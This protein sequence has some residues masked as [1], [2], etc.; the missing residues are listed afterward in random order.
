MRLPIHVG[1]VNPYWK[2]GHWKTSLWERHFLLHFPEWKLLCFSYNFIVDHIGIDII[3]LGN[4]L[5][6]NRCHVD[7]THW[8]NVVLQSHKK[9]SSGAQF[10]VQMKACTFTE[11]M[12]T[13]HKLQF[14]EQYLVKNEIKIALNQENA[15]KNNVC[16]F[17]WRLVVIFWLT[18]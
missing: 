11:Q 18:T 16:K 7:P 9:I 10:L 1:V 5:A 15:W 3:G 14:V 12:L 2:K 4:S 17:G 8:H 13:Y 6:L